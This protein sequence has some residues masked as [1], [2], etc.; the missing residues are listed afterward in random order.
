M[1]V[2]QKTQIYVLFIFLTGMISCA[3]MSDENALKQRI[4][5]LVQ[6]IEA[7]DDNEIADFLTSDFMAGNNSNKETFNL[8]I[9]YHLQRNKNISIVRA[10]EK[11]NINGVIADVTA[12]VYLTG[13]SGW[14]PQQGQKYRVESRW[15]KEKDTWLIQRLRWR[16]E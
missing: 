11:I 16:S 1:F 7:H 5:D 3:K 8:F 4:I 15:K 9:R 12:D 6:V 10:N 13:A 14:L 2:P